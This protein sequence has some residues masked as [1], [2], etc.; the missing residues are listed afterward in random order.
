MPTVAASALKKRKRSPAID[1]TE[2]VG[3]D[4][5]SDSEDASSRAR[6]TCL[7]LGLTAIEV[8]RQLTSETRLTDDVLNLVC[9]I[10]VAHDPADEASLLHPLWFKADKVSGLPQKLRGFDQGTKLLFPIHH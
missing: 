9:R 1:L 4:A 5:D 8:Y 10:I 2:V 7:D 3:T 6:R